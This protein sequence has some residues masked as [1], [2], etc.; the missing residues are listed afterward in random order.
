MKREYRER[1]F[2][3]KQKEREKQ[4]WHFVSVG[5]TSP[6]TSR[7]ESLSPAQSLRLVPEQECNMRKI[8]QQCFSAGYG[9]FEWLA[10]C[11]RRYSPTL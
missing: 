9:D 2:I 6:F 8:I 10:S 5:R 4:R 3:L 11:G 7:M 1:A